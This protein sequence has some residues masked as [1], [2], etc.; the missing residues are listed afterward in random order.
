MQPLESIRFTRNR[1]LIP[2]AHC[3]PKVF[4]SKVPKAVTVDLACTTTTI[5]ASSFSALHLQDSDFEMSDATEGER[6]IPGPGMHILN[7]IY[8]CI[9]VAHGLE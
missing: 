8:S 2:V 4:K 5:G 9:L 3:K 6:N 7:S 1:G